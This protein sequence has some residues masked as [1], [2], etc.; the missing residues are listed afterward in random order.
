MLYI[1]ESYTAK[2]SKTLMT[3][4]ELLS[5]LT[6]LTN[7]ILRIEAGYEWGYGMDKVAQQL[8]YTE[9]IAIFNQNGWIIQKDK[10]ACPSTIKGEEKRYLHPI[11]FTGSLSE[12]NILQVKN[13]LQEEK[14][15]N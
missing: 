2:I 5:T 4:E 7:V 8:F 14:R 12:E 3:K 9:I 10:I 1:H 13:F 11:D 15:L 6:K